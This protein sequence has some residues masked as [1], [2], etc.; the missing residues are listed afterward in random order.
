M[1]MRNPMPQIFKHPLFSGKC[2]TL[3]ALAAAML[4]C[5]SII[6]EPAKTVDLDFSNARTGCLQ[7]KTSPERAPA[8]VET[9]SVYGQLRGKSGLQESGETV[10]TPALGRAGQLNALRFGNTDTP[11]KGIGHR[12]E[13]G[14][15][16]A[17]ETWLSI[18]DT[19]KY[20]NGAILNV[21]H[22]YKVGFRLDFAKQ[23]WA[24]DG[25]LNLVWGIKTGSDKIACKPF[26]PG[27]WHHLVI[28]YDGKTISLYVDGEP[29]GQKEAALTFSSKGGNL[30]VHNKWYSKATV[31]D[32]K[33][34]YLS[35]YAAPLSAA[36]V[37]THYEQGAP[38]TAY[39]EER[40]AQLSQLKLRIP[41]E[42]FGYFQVGQ[43]IPV[44][45]DPASEA[46]EL[47]VNGTSHALPLKQP[48]SLTFD[49]P[50][51]QVI[52][53]VL[54]AKGTLLKQ[55]TYPVAI[56]P[57]EMSSAKLGARELSTRQAECT[58]LG[59]RLNRVVVDWAELEPNKQ[60]YNWRRLDAVMDR[61]AEL[62]TTAILCLTGLPR[63]VPLK[64]G[65]KNL[66]A[67]L[68]LYRKIWQL[69]VNR[70]DDIRFVEVWNT[71][72]PHYSFKGS[73]PDKLLDYTVLLKT[74][75][76]VVRE[77]APDAKIL[78]GRID[79]GDGLNIAAHLQKQAAEY[80]DIF[81]AKKH[82]VDPAASY[83]KSP[84]SA[85]I[86]KA[87]SK[88]VWNT[89]CGI[90][91]FARNTLLPA[92]PGERKFK[93]NWPVPTV[94]EWTGASWQIQDLAL[95]LADGI[96]RVI[97][98]TGPSE[99]GAYDSPSTGLPGPKGQALATF[100]GLIGQD[101]TLARLPQTV[102]GV[103]A[104][105]F[106]NPA[107]PKGLILFTAGKTATVKAIGA[108]STA[109]RV[110]LFGNEQSLDSSPLTIG[111]KPVYVLDVDAIGQ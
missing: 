57:Y 99:Y 68:G 34:D 24:P 38:A 83:A 72:S 5:G 17:V 70:Y 6:A 88:P 95:Q 76:E 82:S 40:E 21:L 96:E 86:R 75:A 105:R 22:G 41:H 104:I 37:K 80:Y 2:A 19:R 20:F 11:L 9:L 28:G 48:V 49:K 108:T 111:P 110:D 62:G 3:P 59:M 26:P 109:K 107:G 14:K 90:S 27:Q 85:K 106:E 65:S 43:P 87:T 32:F 78:A 56:V 63:W 10:A 84:W 35:V 60:E 54:L 94:D 36:E 51:M 30:F 29:A 33:L 64:D 102:P 12:F 42:T 89:A 23:K 71:D 15:P 4:A 39:P 52:D 73:V 91:Q 97:L 66:P 74:A 7:D 55:A 67:D 44:V 45:I 92:A 18:Y 53:L 8:T 79:L 93:K 47:R 101:A 58:A 13:T 103:F 100:N 98:E 25:W 1:N 61:N 69:L 81:S 77:D 31:V 46:D 50:G 16:F